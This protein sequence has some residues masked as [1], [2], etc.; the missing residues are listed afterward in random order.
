MSETYPTALTNRGIIRLAH[1]LTVLK[2]LSSPYADKRT[3]AALILLW[4]RDRRWL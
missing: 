2:M 4:R 3:R 1:H